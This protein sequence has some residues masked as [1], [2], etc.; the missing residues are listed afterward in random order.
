MAKYRS[1]KTQVY[2]IEMFGTVIQGADISG[3]IQAANDKAVADGR[4]GIIQLPMGNYRLNSTPILDVRNSFSGHTGMGT[5]LTCPEGITGLKLA[6]NGQGSFSTFKNFNLVGA[7]IASPSNANGIEFVSNDRNYHLSFENIEI[8]DF[9]GDGIRS[10]SNSVSKPNAVTFMTRL[11]NIRVTRCG[12]DGF[13][14]ELG[15]SMTFDCCY[16]S[17]CRRAG[18]RLQSIQYSTLQSCASEECGVGYHLIGCLGLN[19]LGCGGELMTDYNATYNGTYIYAHGCYGLSVDGFTAIEFREWGVPSHNKKFF[20]LD[21]GAGSIRNTVLIGSN[22]VGNSPNYSYEIVNGANYSFT[23][24]TVFVIPTTLARLGSG[25]FFKIERSSLH[26]NQF[27]ST[28]WRVNEIINYTLMTGDMT[29]TIENVGVYHL[30][31]NG[32][33]RIVDLPVPTDPPN[34][35]HGMVFKIKNL[36]LETITIREGG[37]TRGV[38]SPN[39]H[40]EYKWDVNFPRYVEWKASVG[41]VVVPVSL[42]QAEEIFSVAD[43][44]LTVGGNII[45]VSNTPSASYI[46]MVFNHGVKLGGNV[47]YTYVGNTFTFTYPFTNLDQ[48]EIRYAY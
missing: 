37:I 16:A 9:G 1:K 47:D 5:I 19:L 10:L 29:L 6:S 38:L 42:T 12:G 11:K 27:S 25:E 26:L 35:H 32:A 8:K 44:T 39:E 48:F 41:A 4:F 23:D 24:N 46:P 34:N 17:A 22:I 13:S 2:N 3:L 43:L 31:T 20:K 45:T 18:Y 30:N 33:N 28:F 40:A 15:T 21:S 7:G 36:G 14:F